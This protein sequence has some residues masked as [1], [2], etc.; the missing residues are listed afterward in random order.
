MADYLEPRGEQFRHYVAGDW[1]KYLAGV[2]GEEWGDH[3]TL[4]AMCDLRAIAVQA[5]G[6]VL[7]LRGLCLACS[8]HLRLAKL[9]SPVLCVAVED[10]AVCACV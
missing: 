2:R 1:Q 9:P 8:R 4:Q 7:R 6:H 5:A 3:L 10:V